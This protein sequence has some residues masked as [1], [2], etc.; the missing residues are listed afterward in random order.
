M[1]E[2]IITAG[3]GSAPGGLTWFLLFG[4]GSGGQATP[5]CR[6]HTVS[7]ET[8]SVAV[9]AESRTLTVAAESRTLEVEC[10]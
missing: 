2:G 9:A 1:A 8:R 5:G 6:V 10:S 4:L 7:A 3:I